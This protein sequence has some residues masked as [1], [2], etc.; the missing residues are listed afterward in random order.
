MR[1]AIG[2]TA[3]LAA[4]VRA[5]DASSVE[6]ESSTATSVS[7]PTFTVRTRCTSCSP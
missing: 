2:A 7:K 6:A 3:A 1:F 5:D 4:I